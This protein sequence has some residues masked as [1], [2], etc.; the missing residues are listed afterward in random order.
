MSRRILPLAALLAALLP[1]CTESPAPG[2]IKPQ[3]GLPVEVVT[4]SNGRDEVWTT[5]DGTR[6]LYSFDIAPLRE[7]IGRVT[8]VLKG[9]KAL[10]SL[11]LTP[12]G[13]KPATLYEARVAPPEGV[14]VTPQGEDY[15][16]AFE[17]KGLDLIRPGGRV[18]VI[19][20]FR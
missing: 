20:R 1:A 9:Q 7:S 5:F 14:S 17:G 3:Y 11:T 8:F 16:A 10:E 13:G 18:Q 19:D 12:E 4:N 2:G 6:G 15:V